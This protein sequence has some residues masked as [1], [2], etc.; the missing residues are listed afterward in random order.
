MQT[1]AFIEKYR[2][3]VTKADI[4][5]LIGWPKNKE[6]GLSKC[7]HIHVVILKVDCLKSP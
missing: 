6:G 1:C 3:K 7:K 5:I 2:S 4:S